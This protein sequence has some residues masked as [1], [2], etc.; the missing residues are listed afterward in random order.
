[1]AI[2]ELAPSGDVL[3]VQVTDTNLAAGDQTAPL[4][5]GKV[6]GTLQAVGVASTFGDDLTLQGSLDGTNY[7]TL[8]DVFGNDATLSGDGLIDFGTVAP[9][10]RAVLGGSAS[11]SVEVRI[12]V[13]SVA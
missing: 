3:G 13:M 10:I 4:T 2:V 6:Y 7:F 8:K 12:R 11:T 5:L 1:M 9:F